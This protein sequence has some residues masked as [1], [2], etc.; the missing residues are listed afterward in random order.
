MKICIPEDF[1]RKDSGKHKFL[2]RLHL[3]LKSMGCEFVKN[4]ADILLHIG[5]RI[6]GIRAK[7]IIMRV[8]G[9]M[10]NKETN[11]EKMNRR[12]KKYIDKSDAVIYQSGFCKEAYTR[13]L[14][15]D[16][17]SSLINNGAGKSEFLP[18][19]K[20]NYFLSHCNWRPHKRLENICNGFIRSLQ[21]GLNADLIIAGKVDKPVKHSR[22]KYEGW[23]G[24]GRIKELLSGAIATIHLSWI[25]WCPNAM[26][27]SIVAGCPV[28]YS[29]SGGSP[30]I[31]ESAGTPIKDVQW[32][33]KPCYHYRPPDLDLEGI[34]DA[35]IY[36]KNNDYK[37][38]RE[39][40]YIENIAKKYFDFF[41]KV[42]KT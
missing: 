20:K 5:R 25:D 30:E 4:D 33:F 7:K 13:F 16:K 36:L 17:P 41:H 35:M 31:G 6:S 42:L 11:W 32:D 23:I 28:I 3:Q 10:F 14:G 29:D 8:D 24:T 21:N 18:R 1:L 2:N 40:L 15:V 27:E 34:S 19:N 22:I 26:V 9:L 37:V 38:D 12:T 39:D